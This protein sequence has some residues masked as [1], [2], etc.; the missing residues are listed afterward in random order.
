[1]PVPKSPSPFPE[2]QRVAI[3]DRPLKAANGF[4]MLAA[5]LGLLAFS[6][7]SGAIQIAHM[8][9]AGFS[10]LGMATAVFGIIVWLLVFNGLVVLQPNTSLVCLL[11]GSYAG[12][13]KQAGFWWVNPFYS[14][15]KISR[16]LETLECGPLKV[17]DA[18]GNPIDIGAVIVWRVQD[19]AKATLEVEA[20]ALYVKAQSETALRRMASAHPYDQVEVLEAGK[21]AGRS[22]GHQQKT[23]RF[24]LSHCATV[25][26]R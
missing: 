11:F 17:N 8:G 9:T 6:L 4:L 18:V 26:M 1:M 21:L 2:S 5:G 10:V 15:T 3:A 25:A 7:W 20:Y 14:K 12:T 22:K 19:A 16:R 13:L 23:C 24:R